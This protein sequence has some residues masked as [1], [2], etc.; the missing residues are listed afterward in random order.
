MIHTARL[1][2]EPLSVKDSDFIIELVNTKGWRSFIGH[3]NINTRTEAAAYINK[4]ASENDTNI[5]TVKLI[6]TKTPIGIITLLKR[7]YLKHKDLGFAFLPEYFNKGYAFEASDAVL[8]D[9]NKK[10]KCEII[11]AITVP[12]NLS[13]VRLLKKLG[14]D[15]DKE[16]MVDNKIMCAYIFEMTDQL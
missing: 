7:E 5:W 9:L 14:F 1:F 13:S 8:K 4:Y 12:E 11:E 15:Y 2:L 6:E 10:N 16:I 3:R